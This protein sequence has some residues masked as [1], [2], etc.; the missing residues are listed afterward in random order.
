MLFVNMAVYSVYSDKSLGGMV[1]EYVEFRA[2][3]VTMFNFITGSIS[4]WD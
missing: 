3:F 1:K 2:Q 4:F